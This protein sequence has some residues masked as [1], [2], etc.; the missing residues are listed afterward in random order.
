MTLDINDTCKSLSV[1]VPIHASQKD[2]SNLRS[3][4][5]S[6]ESEMIEIVI[7][8]DKSLEI[9]NSVLTDF[10]EELNDKDL[11]IISGSYGSPGMARNA[12]IPFASREWL[13]F[14]DSDDFPC[15]E[16]F[17]EM[18]F[19][20]KDKSVDICIGEFSWCD[21][22]NGSSISNT[23]LN[24]WGENLPEGVALNPGI[25]RM[26]FRRKLLSTN[27][28]KDYRMGEDQLF[29]AEMISKNPMIFSHNKNVYNY[30][31]GNP[32]QLTN[33]S[34]A[35]ND[36]P[37]VLN[38]LFELYRLSGPEGKRFAG[39]AY[40]KMLFTYCRRSP[41]YRLLIMTLMTLIKISTLNGTGRKSILKSLSF[42]LKNR[43][44]A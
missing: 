2:L 16:N 31:V 44:E 14:W 26:A 15:V 35:I 42:L 29:I 43:N 6:D 12:G 21:I 17:L 41:V 8:V 7:V 18:I 34:S 32:Q 5:L 10:L 9:Q 37:K 24:S 1:V 33:N 4:I 22:R 23:K 28:F 38:E 36:I 27:P 39:V 13:A 11:R 3:W 20:Q 25:W 19:F 30:F 40:W